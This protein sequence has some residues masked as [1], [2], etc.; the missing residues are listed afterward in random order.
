MLRMDVSALPS[1]TAVG[2]MKREMHITASASGPS[3]ECEYFIANPY[4]CTEVSAVAFAIV[5][6]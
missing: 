5:F 2:D 6:L 1:M 3:G 4:C